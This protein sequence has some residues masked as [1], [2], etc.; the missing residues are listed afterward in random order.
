MDAQ[1]QINVFRNGSQLPV[2]RPTRLETTVSPVTD[3]YETGE[4]F[5]L[6]VDLPGVPK[7]AIE[8]MVM[9]GELTVRA[10]VPSHHREG[11]LVLHREIVWTRFERTFNLGPGID[12]A[13]ISAAYADGVLSISV[14]KEDG[15]RLREIRIA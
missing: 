1:H 15:E 10:P 5:V 3:V 14:P 4:A 13:N 8:V 9:S 11:A 2:R 7:E 12:V 6:H